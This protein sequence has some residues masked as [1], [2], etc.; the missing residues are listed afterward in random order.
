[1][2]SIPIWTDT[3]LNEAV[4]LTACCMHLLAACSHKFIRLHRPYSTLS[5]QF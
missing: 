5:I 4:S 3:S 2:L 1:M